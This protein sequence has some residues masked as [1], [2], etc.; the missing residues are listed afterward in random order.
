[1]TATRADPVK[2]QHRSEQRKQSFRYLRYLLLNASP[3]RT[4]RPVI[5]SSFAAEAW[6]FWN[7]GLLLTGQCQHRRR[8]CCQ[9]R[10]DFALGINQHGHRRAVRAKQPPDAHACFVEHD[11]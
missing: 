4:Y 5:C 3:A 2:T 9:F 7:I 11:R 10:G 1:M 6:Y 8:A